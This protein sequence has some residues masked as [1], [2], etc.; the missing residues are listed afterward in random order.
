M[1]VI[2]FRVS[3]KHCKVTWV[4]SEG[5]DKSIINKSGG[6]VDRNGQRIVKHP[7]ASK[8]GK[9]ITQGVKGP[10]ERILP[11]LETDVEL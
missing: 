11:E 9:I 7:G 3:R 10:R 2:S 8:F 4:N 5:F 6:S 1:A